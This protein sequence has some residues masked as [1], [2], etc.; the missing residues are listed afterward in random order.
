MTTYTL[1]HELTHGESVTYLAVSFEVV[2]NDPWPGFEAQ[3]IDWTHACT[4]GDPITLV[5]MQRAVDDIP[6]DVLMT[7][8]AEQAMESVDGPGDHAYNRMKEDAL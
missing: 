3:I 7:A 4:C 6:Q 2:S 1:T 8:A 5:Q